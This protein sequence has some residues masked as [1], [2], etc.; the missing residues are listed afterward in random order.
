MSQFSGDYVQVKDE[1]TKSWQ[2]IFKPFSVQDGA[3]KS[4]VEAAK[5]LAH[6]K[7]VVEEDYINNILNRAWF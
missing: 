1:K 6:R 3:K 4:D 7:K 2:W 5:E